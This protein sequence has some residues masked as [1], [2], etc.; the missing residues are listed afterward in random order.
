MIEELDRVALTRAFPE[1][2][3]VPGDIGAVV[4]VHA[5]GKGFTVEFMSLAGKTV[6]VVTLDASAVRPLR[7]KEIAHV[8]EMA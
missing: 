8:R 6:A 7:A 5:E 4:G 2:G 1:H 3:L